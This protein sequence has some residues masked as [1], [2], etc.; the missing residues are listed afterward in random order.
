[1]YAVLRVAALQC[2]VSHYLRRGLGKRAVLIQRY[3]QRCCELSAESSEP[4]L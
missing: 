2:V 4:V 1:M 3:D